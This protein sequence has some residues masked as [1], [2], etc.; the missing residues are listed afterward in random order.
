MQITLLAPFAVAASASPI[1]K[2]IQ[3]LDSLAAKVTADGEAEQQQY[4]ELVRWCEE[5]SKEMQHELKNS[6]E[7]RASLEATLSKADSDIEVTESRIGDLSE[8]ISSNE[9]DLEKA[10]NVRATEHKDFLVRDEDSA[11]TIDTLE[12]AINKIKKEMIKGFVQ[13]DA[14]AMQ[15]LSQTMQVVVNSGVASTADKAK[16]QA[17]VQASE[18]SEDSME[19]APEAA[20][21][22]T[23]SGT[24][25]IVDLLQDLLEK[26]E[27]QRADG[28]KAET[29]AQFNFDML[30]QSLTDEL[31]T[32][33]KEIAASRSKLAGHRELKAN[34]ESDLEETKKDAASD[35][36]ALSEMQ[37]NCMQQASDHE[38]SVADRKDELKA[39]ATAK[40]IIQEKAGGAASQAYGLLQLGASTG[41]KDDPVNRVLGSLR[42][43]GRQQNDMTL[44]MM[45]TQITTGASSEEDVF[46]KV[47]GLIRDMLSKLSEEA[48]ADAKEHEWCTKETK[49]TT[50]KKQDHE[51]VVAKL[52]SK[53]DKTES[54]I[55]KATEAIATLEAEL[56]ALD[57]SQAEMDK[58]RGEEHE[59]YTKAAADYKAGVEAVQMAIKVLKDYYG[60]NSAL[61]QQPQV[62]THSASEGAGAGIIGLLEVAESDFSKLLA[63]VEADEKE[64][65][66]EYVKQTKANKVTKAEK[67]TSLKYTNKEKSRAEKS[68]SE[69]KDDVDAEQT[70]LDSVLEYLAKVNKR[71][72]AKPETY[73]DRVAKR[74]AEID[75]L[76]NALKILQEETASSDSFLAVKT[77][78]RHQ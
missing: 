41:A 43:L 31:K 3:L 45:L 27:S 76:K 14:D 6:A 26:A 53:I 25:A 37:T 1:T 56:G 22:E 12:R 69:L 35:S 28:Q 36:Q 73:A 40:Q 67:E 65:E 57:Q 34:T 70:E 44:S 13:L 19:Q 59:E 68:L 78:R 2:V 48:E 77:A 52:D 54:A 55:T 51:G 21:Y 17:F 15:K 46:A 16:L 39:L 72:V 61:L 74:T 8:A 32:D 47:K 50:T 7:R 4:E 30:K 49:E 63:E 10:T 29:E 18:S 66:E 23:H 11:S 62:S 24:A 64:A 75:G 9:E 42:A 5:N 60:K 58:L 20:A 38:T 71:C 33:N